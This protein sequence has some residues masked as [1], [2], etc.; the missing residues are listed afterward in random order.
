[1]KSSN[2]SSRTPRDEVTAHALRILRK[3]ACSKIVQDEA[4]FLI[5][6]ADVTGLLASGSPKGLAAGMVYIACILREN[7]ITL[8]AIG[9]VCGLSGSSVGKYYMQI[10]RGLG[11]SER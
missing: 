11:F 9:G 4:M 10:A 2:Y 6:R 3:L 8:D 5:E 7:R 1:M